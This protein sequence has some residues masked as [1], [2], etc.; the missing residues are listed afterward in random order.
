MTRLRTKQQQCYIS[1]SFLP[2]NY[3]NDLSMVPRNPIDHVNGYGSMGR[4]NLNSVSSAIE[5]PF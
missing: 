2:R 1:V 4:C 3:L 5:E